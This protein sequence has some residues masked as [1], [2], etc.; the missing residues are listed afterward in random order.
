MKEPQNQYCVDCG[1][2]Y[3][4]FASIN[5]GVFMCLSCAEKHKDLDVNVSFV[6]CVTNETWDDTLVMYLQISG[7]K[8]FLNLMKDYKISSN[9]S[10]KGKYN[11]VV[12]DY[13]RKS[14]VCELNG[15]EAPEKPSP[16]IGIKNLFEYQEELKNPKEEPKGFFGKV[17][18]YFD[19]AKTSIQ[20]GFN[21][22]DNKY[23]LTAKGN[24]CLNY[25]KEKT[26]KIDQSIKNNE[27]IQN[28]KNKTIEGANNLYSMGKNAFGYQDN[29]QQ[30]NQQ[31]NQPQNQSENQQPLLN[32][33]EQDKSNQNT[34]STEKK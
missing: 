33:N 1:V 27:T 8:R 21:D 34:S 18:S 15:T 11:T 25:I 22:L 20:K 32:K 28:M 10:I 24:T 6:R 2:Q 4:T 13:L 23:T 29:N 31:Q 9:S 16:E 5:N 3:P 7:N 17:G 14:I 30:Q 19:K 26:D 12:A